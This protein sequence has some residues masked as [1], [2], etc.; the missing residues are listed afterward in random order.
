MQLEPSHIYGWYLSKTNSG[1][2]EDFVGSEVPR[3]ENYV[4]M[5]RPEVDL[6]VDTTRDADTTAEA[7]TE[8]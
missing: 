1:A 7:S 2:G 8:R 3:R 6:P 5:K 4:A